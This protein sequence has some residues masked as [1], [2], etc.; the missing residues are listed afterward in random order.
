MAGASATMAPDLRRCEGNAVPMQ[1]GLA[2][3]CT[4][5]PSSLGRLDIHVMIGLDP[6]S[7]VPSNEPFHQLRLH[8]S[9]GRHEDTTRHSFNTS[10]TPTLSENGQQQ[11]TARSNPSVLLAYSRT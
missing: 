11:R 7:A 2:E 4:G 8:Y 6:P 3:G 5:E 1:H 9:I 10:R